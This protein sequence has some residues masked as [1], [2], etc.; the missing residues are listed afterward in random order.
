MSSNILKEGSC[1]IVLGEKYYKGF[2]NPKK[3]KL[4]KVT[5]IQDNHNELLYLDKIKEID[6]YTKYFSIPEDISY[7]LNP[8]DNFYT[9]LE[10]IVKEK[11]D[12]FGKKLNCFFIDCAGEKDLLDTI[13]DINERQDFTFWRSYKD[14]IIF[15]NTIMKALNFLHEKNLCHLDIKP[16]NIMVNLKKRNFKIIDFG[17]CAEYPFDEYVKNIRGTPGYFPKFFPNDTNTKWLPKIEANDLILINGKT[18]MQ[19]DR[20]LVYKIDSFCLGRVINF[21]RVIYQ[22]DIVYYCYNGEKKNNIK[23]EK[24]IS[25]LTDKDFYKR[26][27]IK[28]CLDKFF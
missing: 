10:R 22:N 3:N 27:T 18:P 19:K 14:I 17:F 5:C 23:L 7:I 13:L 28:Q 1:S 8:S 21:L 12:F 2:I 9:Y 4:L 15:S 11:H 16:E 20:N 25:S 26:L 6:N 24:I